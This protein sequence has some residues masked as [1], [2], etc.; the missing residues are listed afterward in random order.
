MEKLKESRWIQAFPFIGFLLLLAGPVL[1]FIFVETVSVNF[2]DAPEIFAFVLTTVCFFLPGIG[3]V[4]GT[5]YLELSMNKHLLGKL[6]VIV[7]IIM[8]NP[9]FYV[10]YYV[11][12]SYVGDVLAGIPFV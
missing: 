9:F 7:T 2:F 1:L 3:A 10:L 4:I 12:C 8:C 11:I 6:L 5:F